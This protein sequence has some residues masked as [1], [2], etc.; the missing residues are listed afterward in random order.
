MAG[1]LWIAGQ[2]CAGTILL[3]YLVLCVFS[4][5]WAIKIGD[6]G[7]HVQQTLI[8]KCLFWHGVGVG[9]VIAM[10]AAGSF[11]LLFAHLALK[12]F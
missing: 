12:S 3:G 6:A 7:L 9:G 4:V 8:S 11:V 1:F 5:L 10:S 2:I